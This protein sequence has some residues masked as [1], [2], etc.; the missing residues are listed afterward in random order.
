MQTL[1]TD[2]I[3]KCTRGAIDVVGED[4]AV[5]FLRFPE[6]V[7]EYYHSGSESTATRSDCAAG[8]VLAFET[9]AARLCLEADV[10]RGA[11]DFGYVDLYLNGR[12]FAALGDAESP[13]HIGAEINLPET[14]G[15]QL[16]V[17]LYL[18]HCRVTVL[19]SL[20]LSD[21]AGARPLPERPVWLAVGDSIT[22]G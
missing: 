10:P 6:K 17:E 21:G 14:D 20:S 4:G 2:Q 7:L 13:G 11:R 12:F 1:S 16:R 3:R 19:R 9:D 8:I 5:R 18:P 22:E 15:E